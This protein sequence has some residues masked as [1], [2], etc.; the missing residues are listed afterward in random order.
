[1]KLKDKFLTMYCSDR[2][3]LGE[4]ILA[5]VT[6]LFVFVTSSTWDAQ[7]L[8]Q[9]SVNVWHA[10]FNGNFRGLYAYTAENIYHVHHAHMGSELLSVLPW[11]VWNLP[12]F[13]IQ[14]VTG[15]DIVGSATMLAYSKLFLVLLSVVTLIYTKKIAFFITGD[16]NKSVWAMLLTASSVYL[17]ISVCYSGQNDILMITASVIAVY[18]LIRG[19]QT[20]FFVWSALAIAIKP[21]FVLPYIAVVLLCEKRLLPIIG[22]VLLGFVGFLAQKL[23]F[24]GAPGYSESMS[25]GPSKEMLEKMFPANFNTALGGTSLF[26][27]ALVLI[28]FYAYTRDF[29]RESFKDKPVLTAKYIVYLITITYAAYVLLSPFS[30]YRIGILVP[31]LYLVLV[32]NKKM[33]FYNTVFDTVMQAALLMKMV[34]RGSKLLTVQFVN[35]SLFQ[36]VLGYTVNYDK[37][38]KYQS[39]DTFLF[40]K[41][42]LLEKFQPAFS[43]VAIVCAA[44]L[45][46]NNHPERE[47]KLKVYGDPKYCRAINWLRTLIIVPFVLM[48]LWLFVHAPV[49]VY[50]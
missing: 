34:L 49:R 9:W 43:G 8:T 17:Y 21:F 11:S 16:K 41:I 19:K 15:N 5:I 44:L 4:W 22:K 12:L 10:L 50:A 33:Y 45:L 25:S 48:V 24:M 7:S 6:G 35:K 39:I 29:S 36:R 26:A 2:V 23:L 46:W 18:S 20:A 13:I 30:F 47:S 42:D 40:D 32:Q 14:R 38:G 37:A 31:Y 28:F 1:M 27:V 3:T